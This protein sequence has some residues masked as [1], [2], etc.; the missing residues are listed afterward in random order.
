MIK[1]KLVGPFAKFMPERDNE[2]FWMVEGAEGKTVAEFLDTTPVKEHY[3]NYS[4]I[5]NNKA[6]DQSYVLR[7]GDS[8]KA[9]PIFKAG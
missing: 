3:M 7:D 8:L 6:S 1:V 2:G 4:V 5:I 9:I